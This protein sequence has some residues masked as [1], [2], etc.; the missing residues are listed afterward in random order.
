LT[1]RNRAR[2]R[3]HFWAAILTLCL[4]VATAVTGT[5]M[6]LVAPWKG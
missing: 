3:V 5:W 1:L 6:I 2:R 4:T